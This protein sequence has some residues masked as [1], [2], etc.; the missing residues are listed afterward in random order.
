[1]K[2]RTSFVSNSSSCSFII[3]NTSKEV[4]T[5]VDFVKENP[6]LIQEFLDR[7]DW[8]KE[9]ADT[10]YNQE[11]LIKSA[12][13]LLGDNAVEYTFK[14]KQRKTLVFGD[15]QGNLIGEVFDY[16]LRDGGK[17][18]SFKWCMNEMLR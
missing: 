4:L 10:K 2:I 3:T 1:M 15:E 6:Q 5:I 12:E 18:I 11:M 14:S 17:S 7:Y 13:Y 8:H 9:D 16:M